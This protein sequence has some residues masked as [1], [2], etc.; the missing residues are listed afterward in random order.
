MICE[1]RNNNTEV[2]LSHMTLGD[3]LAFIRVWLSKD[4][5]V[6]FTMPIESMAESEDINGEL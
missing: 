1:V 6:V 4:K 2:A 5:E 3:I